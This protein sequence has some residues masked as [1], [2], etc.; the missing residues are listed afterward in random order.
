MTAPPQWHATHP[1]DGV[2]GWANKKYAND[3][4]LETSLE[5]GEKVEGNRKGSGVFY[6]GTVSRKH[7]TDDT[8]DIVYDDGIREDHKAASL[9]RRA[10][11][12]GGAPEGGF[13]NVVIF[14]VLWS[15]E[16]LAAVPLIEELAPTYPAVKFSTIRADRV[17]IDE[18]SRELAVVQFPT[19]F[20]TRGE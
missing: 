10:C 15:D 5:E 9:I 3:Q 13:L 16:C 19:V 11:L 12:P 6:P 7:A 4:A 2:V 14:Q 8:Y 20:V 18:L 17:G 1:A